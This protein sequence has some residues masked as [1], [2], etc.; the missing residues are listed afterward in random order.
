MISLV[1][2]GISNLKWIIDGTEMG[3]T[4]IIFWGCLAVFLCIYFLLKSEKLKITWIL[5]ANIVFYAWSG[6]WAALWIL[7]ATATVVY[8]VTRRM[9]YIYQGYEEETTGLS[10]KE[11][12]SILDKYKKRTKHYLILALILILGV[13]IYVKVGKLYITESVTTFGEWF[14]GKGIIVPLGISY[15]TLSA[16]G[17][18][19]DVYWRKT[20]PEHNF[21]SLFTVMTYFPHIVEGPI[22]KYSKL[23]PQLDNLPK[24][25]YK[26]VCYGLQ[27]MLWGYIKKMVIADRIALFTT[28]IFTVPEKYAGVEILLAV[29]LSVFQLYADFSGC[30]DIVCGI[31][32]AIGINLEQNF[33]QPFSSK[34]VSEFWR[35]WHITLGAWTREY[36]YMPI[37]TNPRFMKW[38]WKIKQNGKTELYTFIK[39]II[40]L[41][42][43][44]LFTGLWHGTGKNYIAWGLY[45]CALIMLSIETKTLCDNLC[46]SLNINRQRRYWKIWQSIRVFIFFAIGRM[47]TVA[48]GLRACLI[49]WRQL[50]AD[51]RLWTLFD[52]S[53]YTHGLDQKDFYVMLIGVILIMIVDIL[54]EKG[55]KIRETIA[56]Q[57]LP[58]RWVIYYSAIFSILILGIYGPGYD[59]ASF[60]Y[61]AF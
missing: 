61:G 2:R 51:A 49:L 56:A 19:L 33:R 23:F 11:K 31:S 47:F 46:T 34:N 40:P 20:K 52:G 24:F 26:R 28:T 57:P 29:I 13:W 39:N 59:A 37:S 3:Y 1:D 53:L 44:W 22:S 16:I 55:V 10:S 18:I 8:A 36:I 27:L 6:G 38:T 32:Q 30:M 15:Y 21:I 12:T 42:S 4:S 50:F 48:G 14:T 41:L 9:E 17:Y 25:N 45:W 58:I 5:F 7:F 43:V 54:H 60:I 35:R